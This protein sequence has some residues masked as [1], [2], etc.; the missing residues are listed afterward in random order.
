M[1]IAYQVQWHNVWHCYNVTCT[2]VSEWIVGHC[3][4]QA[5]RWTAVSTGRCYGFHW[6]LPLIETFPRFTII[7]IL[8]AVLI[9]NRQK[10]N[11]HWTVTSRLYA[12]LASQR[13]PIR[14]HVSSFPC[15]P[16]PQ[17][18]KKL[19]SDAMSRTG[20]LWANLPA[21]N[22]KERLAHTVLALTF[23][24]CINSVYLL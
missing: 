14:A 23:I 10:D 20:A 21:Q 11:G 2:A 22:E 5:G 12:R 17:S 13:F 18:C 4:A 15:L 16:W 3:D 6:T 9:L 24:S 8:L 19:C 1:Y 7:I